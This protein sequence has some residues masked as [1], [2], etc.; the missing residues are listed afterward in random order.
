MTLEKKKR[1]GE[2][3]KRN[4]NGEGFPRQNTAGIQAAWER[5]PPCGRNTIL[6]PHIAGWAQERINKREDMIKMGMAGVADSLIPGFDKLEEKFVELKGYLQTV[7][8]DFAPFQL[9]MAEVLSD[10]AAPT[11]EAEALLA[12]IADRLA[13]MEKVQGSLKEAVSSLEGK[14]ESEEQKWRSKDDAA[15]AAVPAAAPAPAAAAVPAAA[16]PAA[17]DAPP[18]F[19]EP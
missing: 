10:G 2:K 3:K 13:S 15:D 9:Q 14:I 11:A 6:T 18:E 7:N 1:E 8:D 16:T 19:G 12:S 4:Q 17:D 5:P